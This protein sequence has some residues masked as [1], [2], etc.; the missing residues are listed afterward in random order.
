MVNPAPDG[1]VTIRIVE[2]LGLPCDFCTL[3]ERDIIDLITNTRVV[4]ACRMHAIRAA[5]FQ[6]DEE[7]QGRGF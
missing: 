4:N 1:M 5:S 6:I 7:R 2:A 3:D